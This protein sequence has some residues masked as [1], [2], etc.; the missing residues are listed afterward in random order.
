MPDGLIGGALIPCRGRLEAG[1]FRDPDTLDGVALQNLKTAV[2]DE[3]LDLV[4]CEGC[5]DLIPINFQLCLIERFLACEY[6]VSAHGVVLL[7]LVLLVAA[8]REDILS[9]E[10]ARIVR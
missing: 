5:P 4:A 3:D 8:A 7:K 6:Q 10:P 2:V 1:E 9:G